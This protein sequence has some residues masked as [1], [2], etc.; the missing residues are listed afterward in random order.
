MQTLTTNRPQ[1]F[2]RFKELADW[3]WR[4]RLGLQQFANFSS[5]RKLL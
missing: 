3:F 1:V 2:D 4:A 5:T